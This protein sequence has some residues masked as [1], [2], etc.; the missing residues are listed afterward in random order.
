MANKQ[1][2]TKQQMINAI[3]QSKG[4]LTRAA[5]GLGCGYNT[6]RRYIDK[7]PDIK[8]AYEET[9]Y[10]M[11]DTIET[12]LYS[13]AI[14]RPAPDGKTWEQEPNVTALIFLAKTHPA[15]RERGYAERQEVT[16]ADG[17]DLAIIIKSGQS[18]DDI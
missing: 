16:G 6:I 3:V 10:Q 5:A 1:K 13:I 14:G 18:M 9:R 15:M 8:A 12:T 2:Y 17:K 11:A 4:M 7:H